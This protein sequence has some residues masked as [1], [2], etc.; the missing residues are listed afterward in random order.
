M[1]DTFEHIIQWDADWALRFPKRLTGKEK[2]TFLTELEA[3]LTERGWPT[4]RLTTGRF[5]RNRLLLTACKQPAIIFMAHYDTPTQLPIWVSWL[6]QL[7][8]HTRP[9]A[10]MIFLW[11]LLQLPKGLRGLAPDLAFLSSIGA[12]VTVILALSLIVMLIPNRRNREDNTSGVLGLM[13]LADYLKDEPGIQER[14]QFIFVDNEEL[15]LLG[16]TALKKA[17]DQAAYPYHQADIISL[18][19]IARGQKPLLVYHKHDQLAQKLLPTLQKYLPETKPLNM[20]LL[21]LSDNY[22]FRHSGAVDI[23]F[24]DPTLI[25]GGYNIPRIHCSR[26]DDFTPERFW[27]LIQAL[28]DYV[29]AS[30]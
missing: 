17:W 30:S 8:G 19:C 21:P 24:A 28:G 12:L 2:E 6:S 11:M 5:P 3:A 16:S 4:Q 27:P 25:P 1:T 20:R 14:V 22:T 9:I 18:D 10:T 23:T 29:T 13:A 26:D 7:W 15:G